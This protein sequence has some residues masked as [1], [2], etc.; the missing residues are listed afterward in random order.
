M[1]SCVGPIR[2]NQVH[3]LTIFRLAEEWAIWK[4]VNEW[5]NSKFYYNGQYYN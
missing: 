5:N 1:K 2:F 4:D 3:V